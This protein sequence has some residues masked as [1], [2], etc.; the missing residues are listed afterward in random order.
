MR[1]NLYM[2]DCIP[3]KYADMEDNREY[4]GFN[5]KRVIENE[6]EDLENEY[7]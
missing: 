2:M 7:L 1:N 6:R 4:V 3:E 5:N